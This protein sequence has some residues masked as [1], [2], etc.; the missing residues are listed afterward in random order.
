MLLTAILT[1]P[2]FAAA[3]AASV[4]SLLHRIKRRLMDADKEDVITFVKGPLRPIPVMDVPIDDQDPLATRLS[5]GRLDRDSH[6]RKETKPHGA[7]RLSV[8]RSASRTP[9]MGPV[10]TGRTGRTWRSSSRRKENE[11][12]LI[13]KIWNMV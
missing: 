11:E 3:P 4:H 9:R 7:L 13:E 2:T 5:A 12:H 6:I 10:S 8:M 1:T